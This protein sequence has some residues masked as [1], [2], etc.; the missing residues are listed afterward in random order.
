MDP[1]DLSIKKQILEQMMDPDAARI[2]HASA[3][4]APLD[5]VENSL[6]DPKLVE[7]AAG[8]GG[9]RGQFGAHPAPVGGAPGIQIRVESDTAAQP[10]RPRR[11]Y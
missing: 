8:L 4:S 11:S 3:S 10:M 5:L 2:M 9:Y 1:K 6:V 7:Q